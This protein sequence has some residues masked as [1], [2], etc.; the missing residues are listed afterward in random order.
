MAKFLPHVARSFITL[1][2]RE[3]RLYQLEKK[4][5]KVVMLCVRAFPRHAVWT[6]FS[7]SEVERTLVFTS[8]YSSRVMV[9]NLLSEEHTILAR[10]ETHSTSV[11]SRYGSVAFIATSRSS[12]LGVNL[13]TMDTLTWS[14]L[15][16]PVSHMFFNH[17]ESQLFALCGMNLYVFKHCD[18]RGVPYQAYP[19]VFHMSILGGQPYH[20]TNLLPDSNRT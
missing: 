6:D 12:L 2:K 19:R 18:Q 8:V 11:V 15:E 9:W 13:L 7:M 3:S 1:G 17:D 4:G 5:S 10:N 20:I 14:S 16:A